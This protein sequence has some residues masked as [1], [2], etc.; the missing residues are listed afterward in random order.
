ME[1]KCEWCGEDFSIRLPRFCCKSCSAHHSNATRRG[2]CARKI[3]YNVQIIDRM[4]TIEGMSIRRIARVYN[5][6][7]SAIWRLMVDAGIERRQHTRHAK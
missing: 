5:C 6:T 7:F 4:Y 1:C 3:P 2:P